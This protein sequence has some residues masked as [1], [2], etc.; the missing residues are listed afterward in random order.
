MKSIL[1]HIGR[2][3]LAIYFLL[4]GMGKLLSWDTQI[5]LME[6]HNMIMV[7]FL[8][9]VATI[10]QL[11]GGILLLLN[12]QVV[13]CALGFAAMTLLIN[14]NLHDFW[15]V[16]EGVDINHETQNF[17]KNMGIFAGLLLL[18][19]VNIEDSDS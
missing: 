14:I 7:P 10:A 18:A 12:R 8:L 11:G 9:A 16:Y 13:V 4:P 1:M 19:A 6:T 5:T 17:Y 15:N 3:L 2:I